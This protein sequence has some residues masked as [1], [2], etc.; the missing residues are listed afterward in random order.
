MTTVEERE[1]DKNA[2]K[3]IAFFKSILQTFGFELTERVKIRHQKTGR[4][5]SDAEQ[6]GF[7]VGKI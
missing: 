5:I 6:K 3:L 7:A 4:S 2:E 1:A